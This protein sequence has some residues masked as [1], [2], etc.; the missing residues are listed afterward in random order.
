MPDPLIANRPRTGGLRNLSDAQVRTA[1]G[2]GL[3]VRLRILAIV[4]EVGQRTGFTLAELRGRDRRH[5]I[6]QARFV[7]MYLAREEGATGAEIG[8]FF[9]RDHTSV[10]HGVARIAH[11]IATKGNSDD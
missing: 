6:A 5:E 8:R 9:D 2:P 4:E 11:R 3:E 7:A 1:L 10:M